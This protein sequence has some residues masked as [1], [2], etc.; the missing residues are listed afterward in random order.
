MVSLFFS[1]TNKLPWAV[2]R[3]DAGERERRVW[4]YNWAASRAQIPWL[5]DPES[6]NIN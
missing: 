2:H 5:A 4:D 1:I 3:R 6:A